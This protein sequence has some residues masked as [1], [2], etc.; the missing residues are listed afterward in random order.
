MGSCVYHHQLC[1]VL[2]SSDRALEPALRR[3]PPL[4]RFEHDFR[5]VSTPLSFSPAEQAALREGDIV[6][7]D[8]PAGTALPDP[9]AV[10]GLCKPGA[11]LVLRAAPE[12]LNSLKPGDFEALNEVWPAPCSPA[13]LEFLFR[14]LQERV[15]TEKDLRLYRTYLDAVID[16]VPD[17]IWFK[18]VRG[19]HLKVNNAFCDAVGK[20]KQQCEGRGHYYIWDLKKEEYEKGE[21]VCLE[22]E[23]IVLRERKTCLF[24]EKV[25]SKHGLRQFK[26]YKSPLF[27]ENGDVMGTVGIARDVTDLRNMN[28][29]MEILLRSMPF[30]ILV[31]DEDGRII[32]AN[33]KFEEYFRTPEQAVLGQDYAAWKQ[34]VL[35]ATATATPEGNVEAS[36][37]FDGETILLELH[38]EPIYDVFQNVVGQ[39]CLFRDVTIERT[40]EQTILHNANT[41]ALT[42]LYNR[43]YFYEYV[44]RHRGAGQLSLLYVDLDNFKL[45][46]DCCGHQVGD[47]VLEA[48]AHLLREG[49][50]QG[51]IARVGGDE[52]LITITGPVTQEALQLQADAFLARLREH[53]RDSEPLSALSAS[54]GIT[55]A[56][57]A[58]I[59]IDD[60][61]KQSDT[62]LYAAKRGGKSRYTV[63]SPTLLAGLNPK[64]EA[65]VSKFRSG[66]PRTP[67][68]ARQA[69][70]EPTE[71][72]RGAPGSGA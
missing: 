9:Q 33:R 37:S 51:M 28:A 43:R 61:I 44:G 4:E 40:F 1:I 65:W 55:T 14:N 26:T 64:H 20:T 54:I 53:F 45:I 48:V 7:L 63:Y 50:P 68:G 17:L 24:D 19:A 57:D 10:R 22:T 13:C 70:E 58:G 41:D 39:L 72:E 46:N 15:R 16:S 30:A 12:V 59:H 3:Q 52:F 67:S 6:L 60:L 49:F 56:K 62:A 34:S 42:G 38:E 71:K 5:V 29:E 21:Y 27:D 32:K 18:D 25:K 23:E 35:G 66:S 2:F 31:R 11:Q 8:C 36:L 69:G 47:E